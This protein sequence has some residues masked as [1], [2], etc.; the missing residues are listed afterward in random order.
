MKE[1]KQDDLSY[2]KIEISTRYNFS[3]DYVLEIEIR[4][5]NR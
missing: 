2:I 5:F 1:K 3:I 4:L